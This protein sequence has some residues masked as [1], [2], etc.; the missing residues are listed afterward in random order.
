MSFSVALKNA[1]NVVHL[2]LFYRPEDYEK[3]E[4]KIHS[5]KNQIM[6]GNIINGILLL[7]LWSQL[8][9]YIWAICL[10]FQ[11]LCWECLKNAVYLYAPYLTSNRVEMKMYPLEVSTLGDFWHKS[12]DFHQKKRQKGDFQI[13]KSIKY[14][15][16]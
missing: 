9:V 1:G 16:I 12:G 10:H 3:F 6:S 11:D 2:T 5:L 8:F 7:F 15:K 14:E 4:A 13:Q